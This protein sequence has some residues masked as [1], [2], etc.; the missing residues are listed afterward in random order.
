M[1]RRTGPPCSGGIGW[2]SC[3]KTAFRYNAYMTNR[4][5][6]ARLIMDRETFQRLWRV[7][8]EIGRRYNAGELPRDLSEDIQRLVVWM[9]NEANQIVS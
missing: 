9:D 4:N 8:I 1:I 6:P 2:P 7:M 5:A 3:K